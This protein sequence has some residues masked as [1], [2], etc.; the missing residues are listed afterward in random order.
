MHRLFGFLLLLVPLWCLSQVPSST[1]RAATNPEDA[2]NIW[3][4]ETLPWSTV[5]I[6]TERPNG[7]TLTTGVLIN[8]A[9]HWVL[10]T[11]HALESNKPDGT[12]AGIIDTIYVVWPAAHPETGEVIN[13]SDHY[14]KARREK[15]FKPARIIA[16]DAVR[17]IVILEAST[18]AP[19]QSREVALEL[20]S[21]PSGTK[22]LGIAQPFTRGGL[23]HPFTAQIQEVVHR[24]LSYMP[25]NQRESVALYMATGQE[26]AEFG[27]SGAPMVLTQTGKLAGLMLA[28]KLD[29]PL[30]FVLISSQE[31]QKLLPIE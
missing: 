14:F 1:V 19:E 10:A 28:A 31:I 25:P 7:T 16:R 22:L 5:L 27:Y 11:H 21:V 9:R 13:T 24:R 6:W 17:D 2:I 8:K 4:T 20:S 29:N 26:P 23:W 30:S 3:N 18:P 15:Q 12:S